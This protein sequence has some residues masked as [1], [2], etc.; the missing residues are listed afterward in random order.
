MVKKCYKSSLFKQL[1]KTLI[2]YWI[3]FCKCSTGTSI[4]VVIRVLSA[5]NQERD[6]DFRNGG[7]VRTD[8]K[9]DVVV[10]ECCKM[11]FTF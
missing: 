5:V 4:T 1:G 10:R 6:L 9:S 11:S 3:N 2:E 8:D 7:W